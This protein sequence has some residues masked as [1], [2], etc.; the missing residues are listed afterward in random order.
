[1]PTLAEI[2]S[3]VRDAVIA[4]NSEAIASLLVGGQ[5]GRKRLEIHRR[6]YETSLVNALVGKF[7][8]TRW[9]VGTPFVT[10]A[11]RL[12]VHR[13]PPRAPC[14]AEYGEGFPK[15]LAECPGG[16]RVPYL[17]EFAQLEWHVGH[18]AIAVNEPTVL[19][20]EL[21][22]IPVDLLPDVELTLQAGARYLQASWPVDDLMTLYLTE[23]EPDRLE[24]EPANVWLEVRGARGEFSIDRLAEAEFV[25]RKSLLDR[26]SIG[27]AAE[28]AFQ[29]NPAFDPG[30][31]LATVITCGLITGIQR[32][33]QETEE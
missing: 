8:A 21:A 16:E 12:Y 15:F 23:A 22:E 25:F 5:D 3:S 27:K 17:R 19:P 13:Q 2:Q 1:M 18:V 33:A 10:E 28:R 29:L 30:A 26:Q 20:E 9:L 4:E 32:P 31:A 11:A 6:H 24:F 14:I 7:P